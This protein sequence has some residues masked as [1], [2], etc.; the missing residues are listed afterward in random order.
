MN[1]NVV[2]QRILDAASDVFMM[3]GFKKASLELISKRLGMTKSSLYYYF[4]DKEEIF[5]E[6]IE[7]EAKIIMEKIEKS[8]SEIEDPVLKLKKYFE[9]RMLLFLDIAK[10]YRSFSKEYLEEYN[11][12]ERMR[13]R[14]DIYEFE[15]IKE[16]LEY[17]I[18]IGKF[19]IKNIELTAFA[20]VSASKGLEYEIATNLPKKGLK[21]KLDGLIDIL[22]FG[23]VKKE[24]EDGK[25]N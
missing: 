24:G 7:Q 21:E 1:K 3:F 12:V 16:I 13:K 19:V 9:V 6:I 25:V 8:V 5:R 11:F 22:F 20:I 2:K 18:K 17:G 10:K 14:Y 23:I 15:K 4:K